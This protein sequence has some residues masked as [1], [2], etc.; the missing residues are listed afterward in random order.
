[1]E[2]AF[3]QVAKLRH[4]DVCRYRL[5]PETGDNYPVLGLTRILGEFQ[6]LVTTVFDAIK[7]KKP[8]MRARV[9]PDMAQLSSF[10]FG[11]V[12]PGSLAVVLTIPNDRLLLVESELDQA[13]SS[14]F[15][16]VKSTDAREI[17]AM[18]ELVGVASI[19]KLYGLAEDHY[20]YA[21]SADIAWERNT[22]TRKEVLVQPAEFEQLCARLDEKSEETRE[23]ITL[24]GRLV[25]LDV[26]LNIFHM[27]F[28]KGTILGGN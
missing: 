12:T 10:D 28:P 14:I 15:Q 8:K 2:T 23:P 17:G 16:M 3:S 18:A 5:I 20:K 27:S 11:Y 13:I 24:T 22:D 4:L 1:L 9:A 26:V 6:E 7:T 21:L 25:G 19:K